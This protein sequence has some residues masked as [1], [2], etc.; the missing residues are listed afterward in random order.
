MGVQLRVSNRRVNAAEV[1]LGQYDTP[2]PSEGLHQSIRGAHER[3]GHGIRLYPATHSV[4]EVQDR[5]CYLAATP[6]QIAVVPVHSGLQL[7][8]GTL[9]SIIDSRRIRP[10]R[11]LLSHEVRPVAR[12]LTAAASTR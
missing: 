10:P 12:S 3:P 1:S 9:R 5:G 8:I 4:Q 6:P 7:P 11:V 2:W